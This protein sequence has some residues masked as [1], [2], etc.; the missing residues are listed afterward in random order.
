MT[1]YDGLTEADI[2]RIAGTPARDPF[3]DPRPGDIISGTRKDGTKRIV[4]VQI[5]EDGEVFLGNVKDDICYFGG[6]RMSLEQ[7]TRDC[8]EANAQLLDAPP[9]DSDEVAG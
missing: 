5:V 8:R 9:F 4:W 3:T 6:I 1:D 2:L 7:F